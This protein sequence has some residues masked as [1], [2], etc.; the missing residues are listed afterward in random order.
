MADHLGPFTLDLLF[1][2]V[3]QLRLRL[4][5]YY[6]LQGIALTVC[7]SVQGSEL[8]EFFN[9]VCPPWLSQNSN[10]PQ[11][12]LLYYTISLQPLS[13]RFHGNSPCVRTSQPCNRALQ[14][15]ESSL[16]SRSFPQAPHKF[17]LHKQH[18]IQISTFSTH[19]ALFCLHP[20]CMCHSLEYDLRQG[21]RGNGE[22]TFYISL[23][24]RIVVFHCLLPNPYKYLKVSI[25]INL[26]Y[27]DQIYNCLCG[28]LI[29]YQLFRH[30]LNGVE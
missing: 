27:F 28:R 4:R 7:P 10:N 20:T 13:T 9:E 5:V 14:P 19:T 12:C 2:R 11:F 25:S 22:L 24:S 16:L 15:S 23:L 26:L 17:K 21:A 29:Q 30:S 8:S 18:R 1:V 3:S 6:T